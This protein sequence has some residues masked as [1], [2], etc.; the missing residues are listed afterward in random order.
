MT[1]QLF[2]TGS[3]YSKLNE[4]NHNKR[5]IMNTK[6]VI[7]IGAS[8]GIGRALCGE[9]IQQG[10]EV[11]A[12]ARNTNALEQMKTQLGSRFHYRMLDIRQTDQV[13]VVLSEL[14]AEIGGMDVCVISSSVSQKNPDLE[15]SIEQNILQTNVSGY[16]ACAVFA[17]D[18]FTRQNYGHLVGI[19][20]IARKFGFYNPAYNASKAF[21]DIYLQGLSLRYKKDGMYL[22]IIR[23]GFIKTPMTEKNPRM[24]WVS[25]ADSAARHI[26][27]AIKRKK[28]VAYITPR[29]RIIE[30]L[31][32]LMPF[33]VIKKLL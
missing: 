21:E 24:F 16:A 4:Y 14:I 32:H 1:L 12:C 17:T 19:T 3:R 8:S 27:Y 30:V 11:G 20:S 22:T 6:K 5:I 25:E 15:W 13:P 28:S 2:L 23:P 10:Y 7:V 31:L 18:F 29:W 9:L 33:G 26:I